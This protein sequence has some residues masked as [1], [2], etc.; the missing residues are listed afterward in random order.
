M[1]P[2]KA[3]AVEK[4][5]RETIGVPCEFIIE[6]NREAGRGIC[7][8]YN[9]CAARA[10]YE[11]LCFLH[12]DVVFH[13]N[14]WGS[15]VVG[16]LQKKDTGIIGF[17]G[18]VYKSKA[19]S[20]WNVHPRLNRSH[21]IQTDKSGGVRR[22]DEGTGDFRPCLLLDGACLFVR[23]D[24]WAEIPFDEVLLDGFH[25]YDIDFSLQTSAKGYRNYVCGTVWLEHL[26][27]GTFSDAWGDAT[28]RL[29]LTKWRQPMIAAGLDSGELDYISGHSSYI[30]A[31]S[32]Y[33]FL[34]NQKHRKWGREERDRLRSLS[35]SHPAHP[36]LCLKCLSYLI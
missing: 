7:S 3:S 18:S 21:F 29:F 25:C 20:G 22:S 24:V 13:G 10:R 1:N 14:G 28:L 30:E 16:Q 34:K 6:D 26:S 5:V 23:R 4:N 12:E 31:R 32:L 17:M 36:L 11:N 8:V 2:S 33:V 35:L 27:D 15:S 9:H 19:P